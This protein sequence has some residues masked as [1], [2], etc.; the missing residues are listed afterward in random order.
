MPAVNYWDSFMYAENL[1]AQLLAVLERPD[2]RVVS[3]AQHVS[4]D[5]SLDTEFRA[6][7]GGNVLLGASCLRSERV[8]AFH[9]RHAL[10]LSMLL[11]VSTRAAKDAA[12]DAPTSHDMPILAGLCAARTA[13][14]FWRLDGPPEAARPEPASWLEAMAA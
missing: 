6:D 14:L 12:P 2:L 11:D 5:A 7:P 4:F 9:L 8:C 3:G 13:S 1:N 10:E